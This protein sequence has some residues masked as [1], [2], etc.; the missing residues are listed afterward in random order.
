MQARTPGLPGVRGESQSKSWRSDLTTRNKPSSDVLELLLA[1]A[2]SNIGV[3]ASATSTRTMSKSSYYV[4]VD[5]VGFWTALP[6]A[7]EVGDSSCRRSILPVLTSRA[8]NERSP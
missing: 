2:S 7:S 3:V 8:P 5:P 4:D 6:T 1:D